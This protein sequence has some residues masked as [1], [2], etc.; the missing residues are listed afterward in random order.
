VLGSF[1]PY[2][3]KTWPKTKTAAVVYPNAPGADVAAK[4]LQ[5]SM[6]SVGIKGT[7][8]GHSPTAS[9]LVGTATQ[10][11]GYDLIVASCN[12]SD[13]ALLAKG[14]QQIGSK[15]PV[16]TPPLVTFIP[17]S[18]FPGGDY[19]NWDVGVAQ[20][21]ILDPSDPEIVAFA[22]KGNQYG[23][24]KADQ[25]DAFAQL[26]WTT[27]LAVAKIMNTIPFAKLTSAAINNGM[28]SFKG[29]LV[30]ASPHVACGKIDPTQPAACANEAQFYHYQGGGKWQK[31]S[32]WLAPAKKTS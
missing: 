3:K 10:A 11:N 30:M 21:F 32:S 20:A 14:L 12:F 16:L 9:D 13:C 26:S 4:N 19:P 25:K 17:P 28:K 7:L 23:L 1:G 18:Q 22:K 2:A 6:A 24:S 8:I 27:V 31:T 15:K 29:P 5:K